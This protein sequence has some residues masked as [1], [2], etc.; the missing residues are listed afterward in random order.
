MGPEPSIPRARDCPISLDLSRLAMA[1]TRPG[2]GRSCDTDAP[3]NLTKIKNL[4][5]ATRLRCPHWVKSR[6]QRMSGSCP[7]YPQKRTL[8]ERVG[9]S[10]LCQKRTSVRFGRCGHQD[11]VCHHR[12]ANALER[13]LADGFDVTAFSKACRTRGLMRIWP[14]LAA[15]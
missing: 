3:L 6:H 11:V 7:L 5:L 1:T 10:A 8:V 9:I 12:A 13:E 15:S 4:A 14:G 2:P